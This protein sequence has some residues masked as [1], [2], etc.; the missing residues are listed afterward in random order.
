MWNCPVCRNE[1][2]TPFCPR[3]GY[4]RSADLE[5]F[6][7]LMPP[8]GNGWSAV[9]A[10]VVWHSDW[11][12]G[13]AGCAVWSADRFGRRPGRPSR[14]SPPVIAIRWSCIPTAPSGPWA[15]TTA[16]S[17]TPGPGGISWPSVRVLRIPSACGQTELWWPPETIMPGNPWSIP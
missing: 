4:D 17:A 1:Y 9:I 3:C 11:S 14:P 16:D 8:R 7:T 2:D 10:A 6:P 13:P 12:G 5:R 15:R